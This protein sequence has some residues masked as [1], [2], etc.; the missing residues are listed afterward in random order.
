M[1]LD[2]SEERHAPNALPAIP[3]PPPSEGLQAKQKAIAAISPHR[4]KRVH[5][6][7]EAGRDPGAISRI[8]SLPVSIVTMI[9]TSPETLNSGQNP[10]DLGATP[11]LVM[12]GSK[13]N[14]TPGLL[15]KLGT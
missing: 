8:L 2:L 3:P 4:R 10:M 15:D 12:G 1:M 11:G 5:Q 14:Y 9:I 13:G 7:H 6:L